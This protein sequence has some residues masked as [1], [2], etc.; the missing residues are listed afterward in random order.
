MTLTCIFQPSSPSNSLLHPKRQTWCQ[1]TASL[2]QRLPYTSTKLRPVQLEGYNGQK[3]SFSRTIHIKQIGHGLL[4]LTNLPTPETYL[5]T[6]P[7]IHIEG[8][9]Y[10]KPF[11]ELNGCTYISSSSGYV[12]KIDYTGKG[13]VSGKKNSFTATLYPAGR[14]KEILYSV[15]GQWPEAFT[16]REGGSLKHGT[17][18]DTFNARTAAITPLIVPPL[19]QQDPWEANKAWEKVITAIT[20]GDMDTTNAEKSK[21]ENA[22][23]ELRRKE[24]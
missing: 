1:G 7:N 8:L 20:K 18:I 10:G 2:S 13:W 9:I 23:R 24:Q 6:L 17:V 19:P 5:I 4:T 11:V 12:A 16:I 21:I 15:E 22:Q 14:E 3:A